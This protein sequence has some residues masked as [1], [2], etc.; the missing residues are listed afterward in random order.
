MATKVKTA[1][2]KPVI[3]L[4]NT[5]VT[6]K[7]HARKLALEFAKK[8]RTHKFTRVGDE[9]FTA[10]EQASRVWILNR[11]QDF[12]RNPSNGQTLR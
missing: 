11:V 6:N 4:Q 12:G 8:F 9:F 5:N 10:F 1:G 7:A 3:R 2:Q